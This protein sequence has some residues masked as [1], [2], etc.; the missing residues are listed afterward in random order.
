MQALYDLWRGDADG[1]DEPI[2]IK[3]EDEGTPSY[4]RDKE[5]R[6]Q[7]R[8]L[9]D[10]NIHKLI[11]LP[12]GVVVVLG[13]GRQWCYIRFDTLQTV[14]GADIPSPQPGE[15]TNPRQTVPWDL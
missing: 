5:G 1:T 10:D 14:G 12:P 2:S 8:P 3:V 6:S 11:R 13:L 9:L 7:F 4:S 15:T